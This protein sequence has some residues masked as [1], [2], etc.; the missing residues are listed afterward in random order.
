VRSLHPD[1]FYRDFKPGS[2]SNKQQNSQFERQKNPI[3]QNKYRKIEIGKWK[4]GNG[5][6]KMEKRKKGNA[7]KFTFLSL[8][9]HKYI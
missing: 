8:I 5:K 6:K 7:G 2:H 4:K 1:S 9:V 3:L